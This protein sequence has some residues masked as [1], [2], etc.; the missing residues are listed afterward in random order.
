MSNQVTKALSG[1]RDRTP[2][3]PGNHDVIS[4]DVARVYELDA[5]DQTIEALRTTYDPQP[6]AATALSTY[7][8]SQPHATTTTQFENIMNAN[9]FDP[10]YLDA[11]SGPQVG[12]TMPVDTPHPTSVEAQPNFQQYQEV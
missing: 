4:P 8:E 11:I 12:A 6:M 1:E 3:R 2:N 7:V 9:D 5:A 10:N